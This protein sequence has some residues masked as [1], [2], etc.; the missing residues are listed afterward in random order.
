MQELSPGSLKYVCRNCNCVGD[1]LF[2]HFCVTVEAARRHPRRQA[3]FNE[4]RQPPHRELL[5]VANE[6]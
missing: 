6:R 1:I 3:A 4:V 5:V 2:G